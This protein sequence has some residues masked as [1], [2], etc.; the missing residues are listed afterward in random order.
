MFSIFQR[1][2]SELELQHF[3]WVQTAKV[4]LNDK[5]FASEDVN[6]DSIWD[7][8]RLSLAHFADTF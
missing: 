1:L 8:L 4:S 2:A 3:N 6:D 7:L 5:V